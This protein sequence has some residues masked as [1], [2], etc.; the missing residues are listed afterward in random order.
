MR[1]EKQDEEEAR[2]HHNSTSNN[3]QQASCIS[4]ATQTPCLLISA[5]RN[6]RRPCIAILEIE[7]I[8][9]IATGTLEDREDWRHHHSK[10]QRAEGS[11]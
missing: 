10:A 11:S 7:I 9:V 5:M 1:R 8:N 2:A 6:R 3:W 4:V